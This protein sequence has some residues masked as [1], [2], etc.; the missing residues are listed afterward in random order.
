[1]S[2]QDYAEVNRGVSSE[3]FYSIISVLYERLPCSQNFFRMRDNFLNILD[4]KKKTARSPAN[5][6]AYLNVMTKSVPGSPG[7]SPKSAKGSARGSANGSARG[8]RKNSKISSRK[9]SESGGGGLKINVE[10]ISNRNN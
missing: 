5:K 9:N 1:M 6:I 10:S 3:M 7:T 2:F 8:S 4:K